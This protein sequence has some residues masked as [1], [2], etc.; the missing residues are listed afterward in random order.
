MVSRQIWEDAMRGLIAGAIG[1]VA[2]GA[3]GSTP[4]EEAVPPPFR[5][6]TATKIV[7]SASTPAPAAQ[8][9]V[10]VGGYAPADAND[11]DVKA[12]ESLAISEIYKREPQRSIVENTTREVQ[13]VA[14]LNYRF[15]IKMSGTNR[16]EIVVFKPLGQGAMSVTGFNK[17]S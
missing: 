10:I 4:A 9:P 11:P 5:G 17:V 7:P 14:G 15:I 3:C 16:Y 1:L 6:D 8:R 2:L 12:A 13:V